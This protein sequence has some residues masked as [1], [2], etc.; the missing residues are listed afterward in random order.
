MLREHAQVAQDAPGL[1]RRWFRDEDFDLYLWERPGGEV[2]AFELCYDRQGRERSLRWSRTGGFRHE[3]VD[4]PETKPGR[5]MSAL[6]VAE[7]TMPV[8]AVSRKLRG[9]AKA[10]PAGVRDFM[11]ARLAE[12]AGSRGGRR[13]AGKAPRHGG[14]ER[15]E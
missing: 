5:A 2:D 11:I 4:R 7:G 14:R 8:A 15:L 12:Y 13:R 6:L 1:T 3:G 10:L 9:A